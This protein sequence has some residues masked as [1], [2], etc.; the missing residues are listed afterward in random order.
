MH[1]PGSADDPPLSSLAR[2]PPPGVG[3]SFDLPGDLVGIRVARKPVLGAHERLVVE[4]HEAEALE[5]EA[6]EE[7][8]AAEETSPEET[9][10]E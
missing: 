10:E 7:E 9:K 8:G 3:A 4:E 5:E 6:A 1:I 2:I